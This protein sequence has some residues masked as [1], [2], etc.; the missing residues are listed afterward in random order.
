MEIVETERIVFVDGVFEIENCVAAQARR[1]IFEVRILADPSVEPQRRADAPIGIE[2][3]LDL[4]VDS[5]DCLLDVH[6]RQVGV[7]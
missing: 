6:V 5:T 7:I 4:N 1:Q 3:L 2:I